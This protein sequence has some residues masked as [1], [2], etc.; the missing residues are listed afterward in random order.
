MKRNTKLLGFIL[1]LSVFFSSAMPIMPVQAAEMS[2]SDTAVLKNIEVDDYSFKITESQNSE[3]KGVNRSYKKSDQ[4]RRQK[5]GTEETKAMLSAIGMNDE[6]IDALSSERLAEF[7]DSEEIHTAVYY[8]KTDTEGKTTYVTEAEALTGV[9]MINAQ[10][11]NYQAIQDK[12]NTTYPTLTISDNE[13]L[14]W[15]YPEENNYSYIIGY[16]SYIQLTLVASYITGNF[17]IY[18]LCAEWLTMPLFRGTDIM[19]IC[20]DNPHIEAYTIQGSYEYDVIYTDEAGEIVSTY[21]IYQELDRNTDFDIVLNN[22]NS[23]GGIAATLNIPTNIAAVK[24]ENYRASFHYRSG[25]SPYGYGTFPNYVNATYDHTKFSISDE[26]ELA[27]NIGFKIIEG[28]NLVTNPLISFIV[29]II[30]LA[31]PDKLPKFI[32]RYHISIVL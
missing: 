15:I 8:A 24:Y 30:D 12:A 11:F 13:E 1:M 23:V 3:N 22:D 16:N 19:S 2:T 9:A 31:D 29:L 18:D 25:D 20:T 32:D 4:M 7:A 17:Y 5:M 27:I 21:T 26:A 28:N 6:S 10:Q 14:I